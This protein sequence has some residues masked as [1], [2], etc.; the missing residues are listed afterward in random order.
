MKWRSRVARALLIATSVEVFV[1]CREEVRPAPP[2]RVVEPEVIST[3]D[4]GDA[5]ALSVTSAPESTS[6]SDRTD[7]GPDARAPEPAPTTTASRDAG[8]DAGRARKTTPRDAGV[9]A[10][11]AGS[12]P[13]ATACSSWGSEHANDVG[14]CRDRFEDWCESEGVL[15]DCESRAVTRDEAVFGAYLDCLDEL[16]DDSDWCDASEAARGA[17]AVACAKTADETACFEHNAG[18]DVY[19]ACEEYTVDECNAS[20]ARF[21]ARY[22]R[23]ASPYFECHTPPDAV[24]GL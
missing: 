17:A 11:D 3:V 4:A 10:G 7:A 14:L 8:K 9:D 24:L 16:F 23:Y 20:V 21:N 5:G 6:I 18:C 13:G 1:A 12:R 19:A 22:V 15:A 2:S